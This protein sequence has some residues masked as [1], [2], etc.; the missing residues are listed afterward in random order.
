MERH[1]FVLSGYY[2]R[3]AERDYSFGIISYAELKT[4]LKQ[5]V[6]L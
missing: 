3:Q 2:T 6:R 1:E 5:G 4:I